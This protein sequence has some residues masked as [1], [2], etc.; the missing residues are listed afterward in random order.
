[1]PITSF[2]TWKGQVSNEAEWLLSIKT[3]T[4]CFP[5]LQALIIDNHSYE[6][7]EIIQIPIVDGSQAY[8]RWVDRS[9][10]RGE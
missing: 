2:Y 4:N 9:T 10:K 6:V 5:D 8:L 7:P 3:R 1:M